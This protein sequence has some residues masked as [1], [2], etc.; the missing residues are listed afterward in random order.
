MPQERNLEG[1]RAALKSANFPQI[2]QEYC[3]T[4]KGIGHKLASGLE[5]S[6][7][8]RA[9]YERITAKVQAG[10]SLR[11]AM[12]YVNVD[13]YLTL[14]E[15][16]NPGILDEVGPQ[17]REKLFRVFAACATSSAELN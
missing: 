8:D 1:L 6:P 2:I 3:D 5:V 10:C 15:Q 4:H 17:F 12:V 11:D 14:L 7:E 16:N 9:E 13:Q